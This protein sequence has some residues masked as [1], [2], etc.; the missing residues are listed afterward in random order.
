MKVNYEHL[1]QIIADA[2]MRVIDKPTPAPVLPGSATYTRALI[3]A[4]EGGPDGCAAQ[5]SLTRSAAD[6][7]IHRSQSLLTD[8]RKLRRRQI[9]PPGKVPTD[10]TLTYEFW[11][12]TQEESA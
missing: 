1:R 6:F 10:T 2:N 11:I 12:E 9:T 7:A 4:I 5:V 3:Y 8:G